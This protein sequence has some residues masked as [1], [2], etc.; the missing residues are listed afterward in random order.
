MSQDNLVEHYRLLTFNHASA[1]V[2]S[3]E[4]M[5]A[6][7]FML[8]SPIAWTF[9]IL[10]SN[11]PPSQMIL[12][13]PAWTS[14]G[15]SVWKR[16]L[17]PLSSTK[18]ALSSLSL[19]VLFLPSP[20]SKRTPFGHSLPTTANGCGPS[21]TC[22]R[23]AAAADASGLPCGLP[24]AVFVPRWPSASSSSHRPPVDRFRS[25]LSFLSARVQS[26]FSPLFYFPSA[27]HANIAHTGLCAC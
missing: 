25:S 18:P 13:F 21:T 17:T 11:A 24:P 9:P 4:T 26:F 12:T 5:F 3:C 8:S 1:M 14:A 19:S 22:C 2:G 27:S 23:P 15:W 7:R 20:N 16:D 6:L 10:F